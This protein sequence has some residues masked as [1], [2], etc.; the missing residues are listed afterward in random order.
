MLG[1]TYEP[2]LA[3]ISLDE[4]VELFC[5]QIRKTAFVTRIADKIL[6]V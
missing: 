2:E 6:K 1:L 3:S 5:R 4:K